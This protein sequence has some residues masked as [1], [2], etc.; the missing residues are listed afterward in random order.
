MNTLIAASNQEDDFPSVARRIPTN[1]LSV[2][3]NAIGT[4]S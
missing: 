3:I 2:A 4:P 1:K